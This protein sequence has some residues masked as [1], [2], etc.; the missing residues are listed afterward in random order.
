M[1]PV[2]Q[3]GAMQ[4][5]GAVGS[6]SESGDTPLEEDL[7]TFQLVTLLAEVTKAFVADHPAANPKLALSYLLHELIAGPREDTEPLDGEE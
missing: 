7:A 6:V 2:E 3:G 5:Q 4:D 1:L